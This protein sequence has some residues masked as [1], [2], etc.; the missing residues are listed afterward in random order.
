M[1]QQ[2]RDVERQIAIQKQREV[3]ELL[4]KAIDDAENPPKKGGLT[5]PSWFKF[6]KG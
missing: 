2:I 6:M 5:L 1:K 3:D 4:Q